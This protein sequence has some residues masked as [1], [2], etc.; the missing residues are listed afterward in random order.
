MTDPCPKCH[1]TRRPEDTAPDWQ[2]PNCGIAIAKYLA[3][4]QQDHANTP[5]IQWNSPAPT[6][7]QSQR[8]GTLWL[9][10]LAAACI[11]YVLFHSTTSPEVR[12]DDPE[13]R[14]AVFAHTDYKVVMYSTAWCPY[15]ARTRAFFKSHHVDYL[16]RDI[17]RDSEANRVHREVLHA[18]GIPVIVIGN[19]VISGYGEDAMTQALS[20]LN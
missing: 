4:Q 10:L 8:T 17:E 13:T 3:H 12:L 15:C 16:E 1:Y 14:A 7:L 11:L 9:G 5:Q 18:N 6:R 20:R 19:E 2:C